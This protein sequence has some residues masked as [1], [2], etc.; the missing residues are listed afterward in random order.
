LDLNLNPFPWPDLIG[1]LGRFKPQVIA[2]S[3]RNLDP[4]AGSLVSYV[5]QLKTLA[6]V[7]KERSPE[8]VII[9]GGSGFTLF[10]TRL[11]KEVP[12]AHL[13]FCGEADTGFPLLIDH[14][15]T[16]WEIPG[17]LWRRGDEI[18][19]EGRATSCGRL[20]DEL[21]HPD[22]HLFDPGR[23]QYRNEYVAFMGVETK[24]GCPNHCRYCLYPALQGSS[25]RLRSPIRVVDELELLRRTFQIKLVHFTDP[26]VNQPVG[27]LRSICKE[28]LKR[29][30]EINWTGF[31]REDGISAEDMELYRKAG[32]VTCYFSGDGASDWALELLGKGF[33]QNEILHAARAAAVTGVITVYHFFVNLPGET[34]QTIEDM[35]RLL[36][37]LFEIHAGKG[38][39]GAVVINNLRLYPGT[40]LTEVILRDR[41]IDP[42]QDLLYPTYFNPPPWDSLRHELTTLCMKQSTLNFL[43]S[44]GG[45]GFVQKEKFR[46]T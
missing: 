6:A 30:L 27:H 14:L 42:A 34:R 35:R 24:R 31:F 29:R 4:L 39:L 13:G 11:M 8:C 3:F 2:I 43:A 38:N 12:E 18:L 16:P 25:L 33:S 10:S 32:L 37:Q 1:V 19:G 44:P 9:I 23:Y 22:W 17:T 15:E 41:L 28:I 7:V 5:P 36:D 20:M 26:V 40:A 46:C 21:P 45:T